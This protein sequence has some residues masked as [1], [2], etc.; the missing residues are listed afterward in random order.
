[1]VPSWLSQGTELSSV[2]TKLEGEVARNQILRNIFQVSYPSRT[3]CFM[4]PD[5]FVLLISKASH[6][7]QQRR[8]VG[9]A[10]ATESFVGSRKAA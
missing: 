3:V 6:H 7:C 4:H 10:R 1:M 5:Q 2:T 8:L 9:N